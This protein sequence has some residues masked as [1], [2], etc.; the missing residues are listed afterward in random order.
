MANDKVA[1]TFHGADD[2][3]R[4]GGRY[5]TRSTTPG[6]TITTEGVETGAIILCELG[7]EPHDVHREG[8]WEWHTG[9]WVAKRIL[10]PE[11]DLRAAVAER[12]TDATHF[13]NCPGGTDTCRC[14]IGRLNWAI[15]AEE[16]AS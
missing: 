8:D 11:Q 4:C 10:T 16:I 7:T 14:L 12:L 6:T 5:G 15:N 3:G 13:N 2:T 1:A 9:E